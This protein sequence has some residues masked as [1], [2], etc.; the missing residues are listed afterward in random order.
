MPC[1]YGLVMEIE[2]SSSPVRHGVTS[3]ILSLNKNELGGDSGSQDE[4]VVTS[5]ISSSELFSLRELS[6]LRWH[7]HSVAV[8]F[9]H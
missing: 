1:V 8:Y 2:Q 4:G 3:I 9:D 6:S 7:S 5:K